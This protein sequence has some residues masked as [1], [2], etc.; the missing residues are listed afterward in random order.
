MFF[1]VYNVPVKKY[2]DKPELTRKKLSK[3]ASEI[4]GSTLTTLNKPRG[5]RYESNN[6]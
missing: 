4:K 1:F 2:I 5:I 3:M 6:G